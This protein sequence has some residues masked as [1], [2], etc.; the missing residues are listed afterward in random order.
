MSMRP[1]VL[2]C[3][4]M[5]REGREKAREQHASGTPG[6]Q[7]STL[8]ADLYDDAVLDVWNEAGSR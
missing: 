1:I 5:L 7:V 3:R 6:M 8:M 4:E 2:R